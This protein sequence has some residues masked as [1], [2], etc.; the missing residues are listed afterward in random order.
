MPKPAVRFA[1]TAFL[2][3]LTSSLPAQP[4]S[5]PHVAA[6]NGSSLF[7]DPDG[8]VRMWGILG[9]PQEQSA[10][11]PQTVMTD[12]KA[13]FTTPSSAIFFVVKQDNSLWGWGF[14]RSGQLR[15]VRPFDEKTRGYVTPRKLMDRAVSATAI[16]ITFAL[17]PDGTLWV[18][19]AGYDE[20][21]DGIRKMT[22]KPHK[23]LKN[24]AQFSSSMT[25][26][27]ALKQD[28]TLW[29]WGF[30]PCGALGTGDTKSHYKPVK[31]DLT[32]LGGRKIVRVA[33]RM[34]ESFLVTDDGSVWNWGEPNNMKP[35][36][37]DEPRWIPVKLDTI[38]NV[39]DIAV[40]FLHEVYLKKDCS[41]WVTGYT[42][43]AASTSGG[44]KGPTKMMDGAAEVAA[45]EHHSL[46]LKKDG[47][48][49]AW[50]KN[51][52]GQLGDGTTETRLEPVQVRF[53]LKPEDLPLPGDDPKPAP[54]F[55]EPL[56]IR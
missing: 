3:L 32:P 16:N 22:L 51:E 52:F 48:L 6:G 56:L 42:E 55:C 2:F 11:I 15:M 23:V 43:G 9:F 35:Y 36:C 34:T 19:G 39:A 44:W 13:V 20:R 28:G 53:D 8:H 26:T 24:V 49:W 14:S 1:M 38:D 45:G 27:L 31:I 25:H 17:D 41:V 37:M 33:T 46:V 30:N 47:T 50:G 12:A 4:V 29:A 54:G 7:V 18:W 21:G 40:G 5:E 10:V